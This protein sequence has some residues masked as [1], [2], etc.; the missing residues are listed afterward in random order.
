M[1]LDS[2]VE[3]ASPTTASKEFEAAIG[4]D[5]G[6]KAEDLRRAYAQSWRESD[7]AVT[8]ALG[9][10]AHVLGTGHQKA[11]AAH[12]QCRSG[13]NPRGPRSYDGV[14]ADV[15][16]GRYTMQSCLFADDGAFIWKLTVRSLMA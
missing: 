16:E 12:G 7:V 15:L 1:S 5:S 2:D 11:E 10:T 3:D 6:Q 4:A 8:P 9:E 13:C 14:T